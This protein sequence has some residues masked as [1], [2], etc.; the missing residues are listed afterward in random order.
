MIDVD[1]SWGLELSTAESRARLRDD[2]DV[3]EGLGSVE[4]QLPG[5][6][7]S[8][9]TSGVGVLRFIKSK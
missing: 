5:F 1:M 8:E 9:L 7:S 6:V 3:E 2:L 4:N